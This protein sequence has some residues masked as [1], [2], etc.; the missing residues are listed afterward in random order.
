MEQDARLIYYFYNDNFAETFLEDEKLRGKGMDLKLK[1]K[2]A[3][4][5]QWY[6]EHLQGI[7]RENSVVLLT[8]SARSKQVYAKMVKNEL[9]TGIMTME[10]FIL[11]NQEEHPELLNFMGFA[12][13]ETAHDQ[14]M[15]DVDGVEPLFDDHLP[16][17]EMVLGI[18]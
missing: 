18:K 12:D 5:F 9:H 13:E 1:S 10:E 17:E 15:E 7:A 8:D 16:F 11:F 2:I 6:C 3:K 14:L 4:V